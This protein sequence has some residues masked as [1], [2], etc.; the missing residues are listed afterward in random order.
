MSQTE[1]S[2]QIIIDTLIECGFNVHKSKNDDGKRIHRCSM[3]GKDIFIDVSATSLT[4]NNGIELKKINISDIEIHDED[5]L[6]SFI[7]EEF[8]KMRKTKLKKTVN[9]IEEKPQQI[10]AAQDN[11]LPVTFT[12]PSINFSLQKLNDM[13]EITKTKAIDEY[14]RICKNS[15]YPKESE[16]N[17][18]IDNCIDYINQYFYPLRLGH[19]YV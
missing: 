19:Y 10:E 14:K 1:N 11:A 12:F 17:I 5:K 9:K 13:F 4:F 2:S 3:E 7:G 15:K 16:L 18:N 6:A 8:K